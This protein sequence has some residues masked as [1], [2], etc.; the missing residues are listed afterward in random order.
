MINI[1]LFVDRFVK[2]C[3]CAQ[4]GAPDRLSA[5]AAGSGGGHV[6]EKEKGKVSE[7]RNKGAVILYGL[8]V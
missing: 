7:V 3:F 1:I 2:S 6:R 8:V 5:Q 4:I